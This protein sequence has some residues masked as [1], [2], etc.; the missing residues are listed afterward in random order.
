M[1]S[2]NVPV[3]SSVG[4]LATD[5]AHELPAARARTREDRTLVCKRLGAPDGPA[6]D[7]LAPRIREAISGTPPFEAATAG[8]DCFENPPTGSGPVVYLAIESPELHA[9]HE[10]LCE[11]FEPIEGLEGDEYTPHVTIARGGDPE[12]AARLI[13][14]DV[15]RVTFAV[16]E[17]VLWDGERSLATTR[18]PLPA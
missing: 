3:P 8:V 16:T 14:R 2:L 18:F 11:A 7:R 9:L 13:D 15:D 12:M 17:L 1:Y 10:R 5:L 4:R 6:A